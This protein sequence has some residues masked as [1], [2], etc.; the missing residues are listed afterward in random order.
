MFKRNLLAVLVA[1]VAVGFALNVNAATPTPAA[2]ANAE[3]LTPLSIVEDTQMDFGTIAP[4]AGG[5]NVTLT[6]G[7][8]IPAP[9]ANFVLSGV[10]AAG[11]LKV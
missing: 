6:V 10:P 5:G 9:P 3:I 8:T 4:D 11:A 7:G 1:T 2:T